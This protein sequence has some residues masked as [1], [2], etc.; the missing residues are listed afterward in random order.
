[1]KFPNKG[2]GDHNYCRNPDN[3]KSAWCYTTDPKKRWEYCSPEANPVCKKEPAK[4]E[5]TASTDISTV[6][7]Y[8]E[9][10]MIIVYLQFHFAMI[11]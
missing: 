11:T 8:K 9:R 4:P 5:I 3:E 1:L 2:T 10:Q 7:T 6:F